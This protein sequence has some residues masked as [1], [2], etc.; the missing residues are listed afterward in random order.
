M[1]EMTGRSIRGAIGLNYAKILPHER[2]RV[3]NPL[4]E[5]QYKRAHRQCG[6]LRSD[7]S[8]NA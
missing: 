6:F 5:E 1:A 2:P 4:K 8:Y 3:C 7:K